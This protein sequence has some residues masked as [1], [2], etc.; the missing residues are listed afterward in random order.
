MTQGYIPNELIEEIL[1]RTDIVALIESYIPL[2]RRGRNYV[3]LCPF[4]W[5]I[6]LPFPSLRKSRCSTALAAKKGV[7]L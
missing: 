7:R 4:I 5:R 3:G 2:K 1:D 6:P